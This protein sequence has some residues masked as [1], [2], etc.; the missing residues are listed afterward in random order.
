MKALISLS[1]F[2]LSSTLTL[3]ASA[4]NQKK[5]ELKTSKK[6][7]KCRKT[8]NGTHES[9]SDCVA[10]VI[11]ACA[12]KKSDGFIM[13]GKKC[14]RVKRYELKSSLISKTLKCVKTYKGEY[15]GKSECMSD[16]REQCFNKGKDYTVKGKK[17][18]KLRKKRKLNKK[19]RKIGKKVKKI[20]KKKPS[21]DDVGQKASD[22]KDY[23]YTF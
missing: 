10:L 21:S 14:K 16:L 2:L 8:K 1:V 9:K 11:K 20:F 12:E 5:Y 15:K 3:S 4:K 18:K 13:K 6:T 22:P 17:C 23:A 19:I 7:I